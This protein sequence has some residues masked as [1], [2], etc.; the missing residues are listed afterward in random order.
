MIVYDGLKSDFLNSVEKDTIAIEIEKNILE[1]MGRHTVS[2]EF[3]S[4]DNSM[5][6]MY[7][8]MNDPEIPNNAGV[9][10]NTI[11]RRRRRG[12]IPA[13]RSKGTSHNKLAGILSS[14]WFLLFSRLTTQMLF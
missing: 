4:W 12:L 8:V 5:Q 14:R 10:I 1:K 6:Y 9:A 13:S 11:S 7:K 3:Q 2:N